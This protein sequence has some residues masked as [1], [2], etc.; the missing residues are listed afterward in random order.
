MI[1]FM[2][3]GE[4]LPEYVGGWSDA[5]LTEEGIK[6]VEEVAKW[7]KDN[8]NIKRIITSDVDRAQETAEVVNKYLNVDIKVTRVLREQDKGE[9]TGKLRERLTPYEKSLLDFQEIDTLFPNGETLVD[10]YNRMKNNF[11]YFK[12]IPDDTLLITHR[13]VINMFYYITR[14]MELDMNKKQFGATFASVHEFDKEKNTIRK[15][16]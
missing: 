7:I 6:E 3:H 12:N 5:P 4:D 14:N 9:L 10:L 11:E 2:R 8:L 16:R 15:I 13:A 1:Y